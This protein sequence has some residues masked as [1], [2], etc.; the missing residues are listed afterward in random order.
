MIVTRLRMD[1]VLRQ[2]DPDPTLQEEKPDPSFKT[3]YLKKIQIFPKLGPD[4]GFKE[5]HFR[6]L[7]KMQ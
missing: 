7:T 1:Q 4:P 3:R 5:N 6:L 2:P